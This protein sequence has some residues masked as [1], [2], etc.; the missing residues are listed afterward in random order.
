MFA[1][2]LLDTPTSNLSYTSHNTE[3]DKLITEW[4]NSDSTQAQ[5]SSTSDFSDY[6]SNSISSNDNL[7]LKTV[8]NR[9]IDALLDGIS[10]R[11]INLKLYLVYQMTCKQQPD[12]SFKDFEAEFQR[13]NNL[14]KDAEFKSETSVNIEKFSSYSSSSSQE[15]VKGLTLKEYLLFFIVSGEF[16]P[17]VMIIASL[18]AR[19]AIE[20]P[21]AARLIKPKGLKVFFGICILLAFKYTNDL[22]TWPLSEYSNFLG[23]TNKKLEKYEKFVVSKVFNFKLFVSDQEF[24]KEI[25]QLETLAKK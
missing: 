18:Y 17:Y 4:E 13:K 20:N 2:K 14:L 5:S 24:K 10:L 9:M 12:I 19:R 6:E 3:E 11:M 1:Q 7:N 8:S 15:F 25:L 22:E 16:E 21:K 23:I